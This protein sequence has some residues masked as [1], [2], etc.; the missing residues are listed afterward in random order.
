MPNVRVSSTSATPVYQQI[1]EQIRYMIEAGHLQ[2]GERLPSAR[3]LAENLHVNRNTVAKAYG[4]LR[5]M[6]LIET[7]GAAGTIVTA[8][9]ISASE[10]SQRDQA[11]ALLS[12]SVRAVVELGIPP[13]EIGHLA[14]N[15]A[16]QASSEQLGVVFAECNEERAIA[17]AKELSER[18]QIT[19]TPS[20]ITEL[21]EKA[22]DCD[23]L[24]TTFFHL[25]EVR[26]WV[27]GTGRHI[28]T[29]AVVVAPHIQVLMTI[30]MLPKDA[31]VGVHYTT[32]HQAE[33][34]RD[35]LADA[36]TENVMVIP[37][38]SDEIPAD[39]DVLVVPQEH[40]ELGHG[41]AAGTRVIEFGGVLDEGS[42]RTLDEVL[43]DVRQRSISA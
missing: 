29:A 6:R 17:F 28:E 18:L 27:R 39:L 35:W 9:A 10:A 15:L 19:V 11:R 16:L 4:M 21:D 36:G 14:L 20:L 3:L 22:V 42:I 25:A 5:D 2:T 32:E 43:S 34:V 33:Q 23:V 7:Q 13:E 41:A 38:S 30:A 37:A 31:R 40:P 1:V 24:I 12:D 8:E 26:R